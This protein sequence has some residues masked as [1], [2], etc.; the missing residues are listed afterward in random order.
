MSIT[1]W[2][3]FAHARKDVVG[4]QMKK[5]TMTRR[6]AIAAMGGV[7]V[8][9]LTRPAVSVW[10][11]QAGAD[12]S[13]GM[14]LGLRGQDMLEAG[15]ARGA[16]RTLLRAVEHAPDE[17]WL[18]GLLGRARLAVGDRAGALVAFRRAVILDPADSWSRMMAE[19]IVQ[20]PVPRGAER[21]R[22]WP[23]AAEERADEE[24]RALKRG[25]GAGP[26]G[27]RVRSVALDPGHGGFDPG[28][29][30]RGGLMEKDVSL[31][32]ALRTARAL[33]RTAPGLE[34]HLTR[35]EDYFLPLSART[36]MANRF[37]ADLFVSLHVNAGERRSARGLETYSCSER[38][39]GLEAERLAAAEN[40]A[41]RLAPEDRAPVPGTSL[42]DILF[43]FERRR[44]W[45][46]SARAAKQVQTTLAGMVPMPDRGVHSADFHVLRTA[47]MPSLLLETGF[48]SNPH[49]EAALKRTDFRAGLAR[50]VAASVAALHREGV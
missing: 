41:V 26:S 18:H 7:C 33:E 32:V 45:G 49:D 38:A 50:A 16:V 48:I 36:A 5:P 30:G 23:S 4:M 15:N 39:S 19:R 3:P 11:F 42:E 24:L 10:A 37:S 21:R 47:R 25:G 20:T 6:K 28:A 17:P 2:E 1:V 22:G 31:D 35:R 14:D 43:R 27:Y 29:V 34:V 8:A 46:A 44:L 40:A 9:A 13:A 12:R